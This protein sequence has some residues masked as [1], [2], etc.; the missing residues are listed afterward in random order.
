MIKSFFLGLG[1]HDQDSLET[2]SLREDAA[3]FPGQLGVGRGGWGDLPTPFCPFPTYLLGLRVCYAVVAL[4][5][6]SLFNFGLAFLLLSESLF[7]FCKQFPVLVGQRSL[8][9]RALPPP[10]EV[11]ATASQV[12]HPYCLLR[13]LRAE[14]ISQTFVCK[15]WRNA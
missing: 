4:R 7:Y 1:I 3:H 10:S 6:C 15:C 13:G 12:L 2:S 11:S 5:I 8:F 14:I 9:L